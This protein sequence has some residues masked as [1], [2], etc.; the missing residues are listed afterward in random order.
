MPNFNHGTPQA[1]LIFL[2]LRDYRTRYRVLSEVD[3]KLDQAK[4]PTVPDISIFPRE[5][6]DWVNDVIKVKEP[7]L[8]VI[9][10]LSPM[11]DIEMVKNKIFENYFPAG[12]QSAWLVVPSLQTI[13][14][15][16]PNGKMVTFSVGAM[17]DPAIEV[18]LQLEEIFY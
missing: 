7:P 16:T 15:Y 13:S 5:R 11:Q 12:V 8:T 6:M 18:T 10:I 14:V 17:H 4:R 2:L 1:N 3:L 9:E